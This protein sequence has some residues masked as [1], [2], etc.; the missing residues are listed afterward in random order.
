M[1]GWLAV[2]HLDVVAQGHVELEDVIGILGHPIRLTHQ[3]VDE[4][5]RKVLVARLA[6]HLDS[7]SNLALAALR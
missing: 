6:H 2:C 3:V 4:G 1:N 7:V 5:V